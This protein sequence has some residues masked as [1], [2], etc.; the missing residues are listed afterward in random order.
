MIAWAV[1]L[2]Q[3]QHFDGP[4]GG[5]ADWKNCLHA[6]FA[7]VSDIADT[8]YIGRATGQILATVFES[9]VAETSRELHPAA[10]PD[11]RL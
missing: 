3:T 10:V 6:G 1:I 5:L 2:M 8:A 9:L 11:G 7:G 4:R